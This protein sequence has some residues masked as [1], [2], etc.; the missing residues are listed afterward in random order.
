MARPLWTVIGA[1]GRS[2]LHVTAVA[3]GD[4]TPSLKGRARPTDWVHVVPAATAED[5]ERWAQETYLDHLAG[6][7]DAGVRVE[8]IYDKP[9][10]PWH[11]KRT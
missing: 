5:A 11:R 3:S 6:R 9:R 10:R 4:I 8:V 2:Q 7:L 1:G